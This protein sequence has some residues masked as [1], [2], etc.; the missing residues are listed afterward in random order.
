[1]N[2]RINEF[3]PPIFLFSTLIYFF[4]FPSYV[5]LGSLTLGVAMN[6]GARFQKSPSKVEE[7]IAAVE[8]RVTEAQDKLSKM[9][10]VELTRGQ[11]G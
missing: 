4:I 2:Q 1:M 10:L 6:F 9:A 3:I 5:S 7:R 8:T 11:R